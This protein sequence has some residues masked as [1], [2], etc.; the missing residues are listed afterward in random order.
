MTAQA[1]TQDAGRYDLLSGIEVSDLRW[2]EG[3][4][5]PDRIVVRVQSIIERQ[6]DTKAA[7]NRTVMAALIRAAKRGDQDAS[8]LLVFGGLGELSAATS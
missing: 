3:A 2:V 7:K 5:R 6:P 1:A 4:E 8:E